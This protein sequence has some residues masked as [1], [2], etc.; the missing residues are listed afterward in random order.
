MTD[1][2]ELL[3]PGLPVDRA[4][5]DCGVITAAVVTGGCLV[6]AEVGV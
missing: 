6:V 3:V 1:P 2:L 5:N 4:P